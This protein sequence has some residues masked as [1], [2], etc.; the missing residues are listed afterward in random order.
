MAFALRHGRFAVWQRIDNDAFDGFED[1]VSVLVSVD[2]DGV[3]VVLQQVVLVGV[4][5]AQL[6]PD[7]VLCIDRVHKKPVPDLLGS[8]RMV[9][10]VVV[11]ARDRIGAAQGQP[12]HDRL[13]R[14]IEKEYS[15]TTKKSTT[16]M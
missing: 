7:R 8:R 4:V 11:I 16:W 13:I 14:Y 3:A 10:Q 2:V 5:A 15:V 9:E 6:A 1:R 12:L